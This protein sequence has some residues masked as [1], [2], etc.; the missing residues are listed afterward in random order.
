MEVNGPERPDRMD[1][2]RRTSRVFLSPSTPRPAFF[3]PVAAHARHA[4]GCTSLSTPLHFVCQNFRLGRRGLRDA[5]RRPAL[6]ALIP[7]GPQV[8]NEAHTLHGTLV[9]LQA[10]LGDARAQLLQAGDERLEQN[11]LLREAMS[12][13]RDAASDCCPSLG[14]SGEVK[15]NTKQPRVAAPRT[16][17]GDSEQVDHTKITFTLSYMKDGSASQ[18]ANNVV[19]AMQT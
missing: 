13:L 3:T 15:V 8:H 7:A 9:G 19:L 4:A 18:W 12:T 11:K 14:T 6:G 16:F 1:L 2:T 17:N 5:A 10:Q